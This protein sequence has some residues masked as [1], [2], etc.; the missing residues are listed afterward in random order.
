[1]KRKVTCFTSMALVVLMAVSPVAGS[2]ASVFAA[3]PS[4]ETTAIQ[5]IPEE[6]ETSDEIVVETESNAIEIKKEMQA[7]VK[8]GDAGESD[9]EVETEYQAGDS[10]PVHVTA[11]NPTDADA[12]FRL[13]FWDYGETLPEDKSEWSKV[14]TDA[15]KDVKIAELQDTDKYAVDLKQ[16]EDTVQS[17]ASFASEKDDKDQLTAAYLSIEIPAEASLD[18]V[19]HISSDTAET[20]TIV[21][22]FDAESENAF[23]GDTA[24]AQWKENPIVVEADETK[25]TGDENQILVQEQTEEDENLGTLATLL[26]EEKNEGQKVIAQ[27]GD[28][29]ETLELETQESLDV[30]QNRFPQTLSIT[31]EDG[32]RE[33]I[34]VTWECLSDYEQTAQPI[35]VFEAV[36]P[37]GYAVHALVGDPT[38]EV[39]ILANLSDEDLDVSPLVLFPD[40]PNGTQTIDKKIGCTKDIG[41]YLQNIYDTNKKYYL[42][43]PYYDRVFEEPYTDWLLANGATADGKSGHMNC[44]GFVADVIRKC[45]GDLTK[46]TQRRPG[47]YANASNWQ[48]YAHG[49][50]KQPDGTWA[51]NLLLACKTYRFDSISA[52][53][54]S[55][56]MEKGDIIFFEPR[57]WTEPGADCH[58]GF[59]FGKTSSEN[60]FWHSS[61]HGDAIKE[62]TSPGNM[63]SAITPKVPSYLYV[64]KT[65]HSPKKGG[66]SIQKQSA[67]TS[68]SNK[69]SNGCYSLA[70]AK[71]GVYSDSAC[72]TLVTTI[73]TD[74]SGYAATKDDALTEGT[75]YVKETTASKGFK[76]D[77][78][79]YKFTVKGGTTAAQNKQTSSEPPKTGKIL[80]QKKS[81]DADT[82]TGNNRYSI[83]GAE[84]TVYSNKVCTVKVGTI[85]TDASGQ[86]SLAGLPL[87]VYFVKETKA[88]TGFDID[89]N[90]YSADISSGTTDEISVNLTSVEPVQFGELK[91]IKSSSSP[92]VTTGNTNYSL[93]GAEYTVYTDS[94]CKQTYGKITTDENGEGTLSNLPFGIYYVKETK[95]PKGYQLDTV[96]HAVTI[97]GT[98]VV[99]MNLKDV[100]KVGELKIIKQ[101]A[102]T[103]VTNNNSNYSLKGAVYTVY[104]DKACQQKV[105]TI[106]TDENGSGSLGNLPLGTYYVKETKAPQGYQLDTEIYTAEIPDATVVTMNMEDKPEVGNLRIIKQSELPEI[107]ENNQCYSLAGAEF[108]IYKD[109]ACKTVYQ[110]IKTNADGIAECHDMPL[111]DYWVKETKAPK[112]FELNTNWT[113]KATVTASHTAEKPL[114]YTCKD[115]P[116]NDPTG[117]EIT[118]L[119]NGDKTDT[120]PTLE[121]TQ[122]TI[123][124]YDGFYDSVSEL[125]APT[126]T[127]VLEVK[128]VGNTERY[129]TGLTDN[130]L[131]DGSD[132]LYYI[133]GVPCL[134]YGTITIQET[135]PAAGYTLDGYLVNKDTGEVVSQN[136]EIYIAQ[137]NKD[138]GAVRLQ[139][140]NEFTGYNTPKSSKIK[141]KKFDSDGKNPLAGVVFEIK[142]SDGEVVGTKTTD[143]NGEIIFD[144]LYPDIYTITEK[145]TV[146]GHSLLKDPIVVKAPM[147]VTEDYINDY[148]ISKSKVTYDP[149]TGTYYI[150]EFTYEITNDVTFKM[151]MSGGFTTPMT[152]VPLI[153]G[154]GIMGGLG[155]VGFRRKRKK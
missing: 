3:E 104:K 81:G 44:T 117:I 91:I 22:V 134:P 136:S 148:N 66:L 107:S 83:Q 116:G 63:I 68:I 18:T 61:S 23:Y 82:T 88:S 31:L 113:Q 78:K 103:S 99:T 143:R 27:I 2:S 149:A 8:I 38:I 59:F 40:N 67:N 121:G 139:G 13:Y 10:I 97:P 17:K 35:Y 102:D 46:I 126:R 120:I 20:V 4:D 125:P 60:K 108:T 76:L 12:D 137:I 131:V 147:E 15:C 154:M 145:E 34:E 96:V 100:P 69:Y 16:G 123:K 64:F 80:L 114:T 124:Y 45:G 127:W 141:L 153:A 53:L 150:Y 133:N 26:E 129:I 24:V 101:S 30:L 7:S 71:Y 146:P 42:G 37:D 36:L 112:G 93:K 11:E 84:Y 119:Q 92:T 70:G 77:T 130:Y 47:W 144:N 19:F 56:V 140:G 9:I 5:V 50:Q 132:E 142:N 128:E 79:I 98:A 51:Q 105:G 86:G 152:F 14:L 52:A 75:Y 43:T 54:Q 138:S 62:G 41:Q 94:S 106:T 74:A 57:D 32:T 73:T 151:P 28:Y 65:Y 58:I 87:G 29:T 55:G 25:D 6:D 115:V 109:A 122:F 85:V 135:K 21:P 33:D 39:V 118:K 155:V 48:D 72:K 110:V 111:G 1:M 90:V 89:T 49:Y 95:A